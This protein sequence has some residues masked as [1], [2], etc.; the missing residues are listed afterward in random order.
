MQRLVKDPVAYRY[1]HE[2]GLKCTMLLMNGL[3]EDFNF[4]AR[5]DGRSQP[6]STQMYLPMPPARTTPRELLQPAGEQHRSRC[7]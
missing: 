2:D 6:F 7:S 1:E 5:I 4:A 3:V